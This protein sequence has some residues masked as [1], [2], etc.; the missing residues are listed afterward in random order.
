[1]R[2]AFI[3]KDPLPN[4][5]FMALAA[6]AVF[7]GHQ[8]TTFIP[9][10]ER[11]L[12][13]ALRRF[14]PDALLFAP[15]GGTQDWATSTARSL[16]QVTGGAPNLFA[17]SYAADHPDLA[18]S[19][20]VD[21]LLVGDPETTF[22][23]LLAKLDRGH[24]KARQLPGTAGTITQ[25]SAGHRVVGA[26]RRPT[27]H[28]DELPLADLEIYRRYPFVRQQTTLAFTTGRGC[29]ENSHADF[30]IG[31]AELKRRFGSSRRH[32]VTEA[33][34][35]LNLHIRRR[36]LYRR[37]AFRDDSLLM[38]PL[39]TGSP[40]DDEWLRSFLDV[41]QE[42]IQLPFS[43]VARADQLSDERI[44]RLTEAG[45]DR[46]LLGV[47]SGDP[48]LRTG[49]SGRDISDDEIVH[50][51]AALKK[52][53]VTLQTVTFLGLNGETRAT[54]LAGLDLNLRLAPAHAF[55]ILAEGW[56]SSPL[57]LTTERFR[58]LFPLAVRIPRLRRRIETLV[59][60]RSTASL[61][62]LFQLHHDASF[63]TSGALPASDILRIAAG[64]KRKRNARALT[65]APS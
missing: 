51:A 11:N 18:D 33:I 22:P 7:L 64:M 49:L 6:A 60:T 19:D 4:P 43:C 61:Q 26:T 56:E 23:E 28:L 15:H 57:G 45:C 21:L 30:R 39:A 62:R 37:I 53:G 48:G 31:L 2:V 35:R 47:E 3:Q 38:D 25:D 36:P 8:V 20:G 58:L 5:V 55:A 44:E 65:G 63:V 27:E 46:V 1:M 59:D 10:A 24:G 54:A 9:A 13:R 34:R 16:R 29:L 42:E 52:R 32:S 40:K 12:G 14:A 50:V 41:Y 17:G